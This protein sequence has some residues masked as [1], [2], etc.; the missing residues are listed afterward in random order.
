M[1]NI[2]TTSPYEYSQTGAAAFDYEHVTTT[3]TS[4]DDCARWCMTNGLLA[5]D[6]MCRK[7]DSSMKLYLASSRWRCSRKGCGIERSV[8]AGSLFEHSRLPL[9]TCVRLVYMWCSGVSVT[10]A[11]EWADVSEKTA[12]KWFQQC[13]V[14]STREMACCN[15]QVSCVCADRGN[16]WM[17]CSSF[18]CVCRLA[19]QD[20]LSRSTKQA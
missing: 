13:R 3:T 6:M 19:D 14:V 4:D 17:K 8:R 2:D 18:D 7:C 9:R 20:M 16:E 10:V 5:S 1:L 15:M 12:I 11:S